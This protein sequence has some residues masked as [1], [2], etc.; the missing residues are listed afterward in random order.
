MPAQFVHAV[1]FTLKE[2]T[3]EAQIDSQ[4]ADAEQL[5]AKI[6]SVRKIDSGRRDVRLN[7]DVN[8]KSFTVG[9]VVYF[10]DKEGYDV[11]STHPLHLQYMDKYKAHWAGVK[12]FDFLTR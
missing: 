3:P 9:L 10:D 2:G 1:F 4:I 5:L 6:P 8:D 7:R 12:V 11:Y